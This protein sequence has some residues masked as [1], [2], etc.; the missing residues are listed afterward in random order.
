M[1]EVSSRVGY[2]LASQ[3]NSGHWP[4]YVY[5]LPEGNTSRPTTPGVPQNDIYLTSGV[6]ASPSQLP[7]TTRVINTDWSGYADP[8]T[9]QFAGETVIGPTFT[10]AQYATILCSLYGESGWS[11]MGLQ[12]VEVNSIRVPEN[13]LTNAARFV[14]RQY[15]SLNNP[16][17]DFLDTVVE[18]GPDFF[19]TNSVQVITSVGSGC[20]VDGGAVSIT[21][22]MLLSQ[23]SLGMTLASEQGRVGILRYCDYRCD[24]QIGI[25]D[26]LGVARATLGITPPVSECP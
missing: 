14:N 23:Y 5:F 21:D 8:G 26:V 25:L 9:Q 24:G 2:V 7:V 16:V 17:G 11:N 19:V 3:D 13:S 20:N 22:A 12:C 15:A 1:G 18:Q 10:G 4:S 6:A